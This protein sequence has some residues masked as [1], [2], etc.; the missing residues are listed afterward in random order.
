LEVIVV[1]DHHPELLL[2]VKEA[3]P[4]VLA[5]ASD[6]PQG[7][8]GA[9]NSG[10]AAA[11]GDVVAFLDDDAIAGNGWLRNLLMPFAS[12]RVAAVGGAVQPDWEVTPPRWL[13]EEFYWVVGCSYRGLPVT[14][15]EIRNPIGANMAFRREVFTSIGGFHAGVGRI[16]TLPAGC[17]E[18]ELC[19]RLRQRWPNASVIYEP[20]AIVLHRVPQQRLTWR[21]FRSR[22][23]AE[24]RSKAIVSR[25]VG[26]SD[27][28]AA[29][30]PYTFK[31]LPSG[32]LRAFGYGVRHADARI[33]ARALAIGAGLAMTSVGYVQGRL[34]A[35]NTRPAMFPL[36]PV[37]QVTVERHES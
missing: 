13:P 4:E 28:L 22:C 2:R 6:G 26:A 1:V 21:Y 33:S 16:G 3:F 9:R 18:T 23:Y 29:E 24:G 14:R 10:V 8:S 32:A 36:I 25:L 31:V 19:I 37:P 7:L 12:S 17:E 20:R 27:G 35:S 34:T 15:R 11:K 30:R 5:I